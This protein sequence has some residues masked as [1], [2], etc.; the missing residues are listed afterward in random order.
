MGV[1]LNLVVYCV[2]YKYFWKDVWYLY[3]LI[4]FVFIYDVLVFKVLMFF[5]FYCY[6]LYKCVFWL[7]SYVN[8]YIFNNKIFVNLYLYDV[9]EV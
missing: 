3:C 8:V 5:V 4:Y 9:N 6:F 1:V 2:G 7:Y